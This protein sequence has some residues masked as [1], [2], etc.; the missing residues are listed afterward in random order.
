MWRESFF[1]LA[2]LN[3]VI[4]QAEFYL[5]FGDRGTITIS[6]ATMYL[7]N[8]IFFIWL[9]N[10]IYFHKTLFYWNIFYFII[11]ILCYWSQ[12]IL[13]RRKR[14]ESY[15]WEQ[16]KLKSTKTT[17]GKCCIIFYDFFYHGRKQNI[18]VTLSTVI[19]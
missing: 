12:K 18:H 11:N 15:Q 10:S 19:S 16:D 3:F 17:I 14:K 2:L 9:I 6:E 4:K 7:K 13:W 1:L 8:L 5:C